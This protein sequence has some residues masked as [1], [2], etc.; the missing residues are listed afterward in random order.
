MKHATA[1]IFALATLGFASSAF[2]ASSSTMNHMMKKTTMPTCKGATV[3]AVASTKSYY[4]KGAKMYG[5][6]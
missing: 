6:A 2:A 1:F 5:H 3:Y 4:M